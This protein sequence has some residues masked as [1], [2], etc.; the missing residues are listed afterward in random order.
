MMRK[1]GAEVMKATTTN[2][3]G[4]VDNFLKNVSAKKVC[5]PTINASKTLISLSI[6]MNADQVISWAL[7]EVKEEDIDITCARST[8]TALLKLLP[9]GAEATA[10]SQ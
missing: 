8:L 2:D 1:A 7:R 9:G 5:M 3:H 10:C 4:T 6:C